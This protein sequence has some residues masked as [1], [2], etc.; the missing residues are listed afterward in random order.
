MGGV[1]SRIS[2]LKKPE[3]LQFYKEVFSTVKGS[4][5]LLHVQLGGLF[6]AQRHLQRKIMVAKLQLVLCS[7]NCMPWFRAMSVQK[8]GCLS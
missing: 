4:I 7:L 1:Q 2:N 3:L 8:K 6:T 5:N